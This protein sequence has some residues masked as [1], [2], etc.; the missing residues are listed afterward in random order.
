MN[1]NMPKLFISYRRHDTAGYARRLY[2]GITGRLGAHNIFMDIHFDPGT[3]SVDRIRQ[4]VRA[5]DVM[6]VIV[7]PRWATLETPDGVARLS[8]PQDFVRLEV[9]A[10]LHRPDVALVP[11][12]VAGARM[13]EPEHVPQEIRPLTYLEAL[14]I[15][16]LRWCSD[17]DRLIDTVKTYP[18]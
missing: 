5:C 10:G 9:E 8:D 3:D 11:V 4:A 1:R 15:T 2:D 12:L 18:R 14:E 17:L 16:E 6:L 7:G 13:P